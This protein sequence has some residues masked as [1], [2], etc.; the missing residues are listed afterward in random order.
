MNG[1]GIGIG[2]ILRNFR[3]DAMKIIGISL[4]SLQKS[5]LRRPR[6][7][8]ESE[9]MLWSLNSY[10]EALR[11]LAKR[12]EWSDL[13]KAHR[14]WCADAYLCGY[15]RGARDAMFMTM[16]ASEGWHWSRRSRMVLDVM[17]GFEYDRRPADKL[18]IKRDD[19]A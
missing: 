11:K 13:P 10:P 16:R 6:Q 9:L 1:P 18:E 8:L 7:Y 4:I 17:E 5:A 12:Q 15:F 3:D 14:E 19:A 2:E